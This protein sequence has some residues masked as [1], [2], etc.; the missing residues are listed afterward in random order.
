MSAT[1]I[2]KAGDTLDYLCWAHYGSTAG[3]TVEIVL[4]AND[5]L[6]Q[7]GALLPA[8]V[9]VY[10]PDIEAQAQTQGVSLWD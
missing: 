7:Y 3:R 2:S 10:M 9:H 1:I 4:S 6:A 8:G 5:H